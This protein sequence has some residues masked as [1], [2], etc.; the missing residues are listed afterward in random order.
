MYF[1]TAY[2]FYE[3]RNQRRLLLNWQNTGVTC[4]VTVLWVRTVALSD[5]FSD[6][7]LGTMS[8]KKRVQLKFNTIQ[9]PASLYY[10]YI[11]LAT[12]L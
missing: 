10:I 8:E 12:R 7:V 11:I 6:I 2:Y 1:K 4:S 3:I 5:I 9:F